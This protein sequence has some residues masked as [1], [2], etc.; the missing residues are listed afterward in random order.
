MEKA[1]IMSGISDRNRKNAALAAKSVI[2]L[3]LNADEKL[4]KK[5]DDLFTF[6]HKR[7]KGPGM[8]VPVL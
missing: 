3:L 8:P 6:L 1:S 7:K 5:K 4:C 2:F